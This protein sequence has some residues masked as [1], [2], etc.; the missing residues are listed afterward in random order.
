MKQEKV[1]LCGANAYEEK[2]Y[3]NEKFSGIPKSI[4]EEL[5][6]ICVL[7]TQEAGGIFTISP[8]LISAQ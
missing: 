4:R 6:V 3:F 5:R 1:V 2:Y 7:I 8:F